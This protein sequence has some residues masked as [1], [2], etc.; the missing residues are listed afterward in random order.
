MTLPT[1]LG[2]YILGD[3]FL[4]GPLMATAIITALP[5]VIL[6]IVVQRFIVAGMTLGSVKG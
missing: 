5:P 2:S 4:W 1:G 3:V 6:F